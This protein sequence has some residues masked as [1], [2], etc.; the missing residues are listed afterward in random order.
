MKTITRIISLILVLVSVLT[1]TT[2]F[3]D[4]SETPEG[5]VHFYWQEAEEVDNTTVPYGIYRRPDQP[6][7]E[8]T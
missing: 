5:H 1:G 2:A 6:F 8:R 3:A 7:V 4:S